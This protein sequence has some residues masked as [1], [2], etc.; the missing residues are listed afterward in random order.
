MNSPTP[1]RAPS[2]LLP[3]FCSS[4][5]VLS[6]IV[7]A[8]LIACVLVLAPA[9][10]RPQDR[11]GELGVVSMFVQWVA[12][13]TCVL[14]C[15][16]RRYLARWSDLAALAASYVV[17]LVLTLAYSMLA[18]QYLH[19][20]AA[21]FA[22]D[23]DDYRAFLLSNLAIVA[24]VGAVVLRY[25]YVRQQWR[26]HIERE[27]EVRIEMLQARIRPHFLFNS[28]NTIAALIPERP[29]AAEAAV[30]DL[31][32]LFRASLAEAGH[33]VELSAELELT[34]RYLAIEAL[35]LGERLRIQWDVGPYTEHARLPLL[36]LQPLAENAVYHGIEPRPEGG[37]L[38]ISVGQH[39]DCI[40]ITVTNPKA[41]AHGAA[42]K[43]GN[44]IALTNV[45]ARLALIYGRRARLEFG[46]SGAD[47]RVNLV[48]P[49]RMPSR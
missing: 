48:F 26:R 21:V 42:R 4:R 38:T 20:L 15:L 18:Y 5:T 12:L 49:C 14:L 22:F 37:V 2:G 11:W 1:L 23:R 7:I 44:R 24:I 9:A 19:D 47:Y 27:A 6:V 43:H 34:R 36:T 30:L 35:R 3:N 13:S 10:D 8:E 33:V 29:Q 46:E 31:A 45:R 16:T 28:L 40:H 39:D 41:S 32:D 17:M 25:F